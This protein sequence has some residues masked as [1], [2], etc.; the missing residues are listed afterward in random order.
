MPN[1]A[2][3]T[4]V[5]L[6]A[7]DIIDWEDIVNEFGQAQ[8]D[9]AFD[10]ADDGT[11]VAQAVQRCVRDA[12]SKVKAGAAKHYAA[13]IATITPATAHHLLKELSLSFFR[14]FASRK[15]NLWDFNVDYSSERESLRREVNDL[16]MNKTVLDGVAAPTNTGGLITSGNTNDP[17]PVAGTYQNGF[18]DY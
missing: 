1:E 9:R 16:A 5:T 3:V 18:G 14:L 10:D 6:V 12:E 4:D 8:L 15:V 17:T 2:A 13:Y 11:P 7:G